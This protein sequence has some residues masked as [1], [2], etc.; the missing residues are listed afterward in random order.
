MVLNDFLFVL[1]GD[2]GK[3]MYFCKQKRI[4]GNKEE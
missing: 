1:L 3:I 2:M 4:K